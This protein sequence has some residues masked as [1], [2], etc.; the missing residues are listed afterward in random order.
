MSLINWQANGWLQPHRTSPQ[1][2]VGLLAIVERDLADSEADDLSADWRLNIAY[3]AALQSAKAAL[4]ASGYLPGKAGNAHYHTLQS[5]TLTIGL[6]SKTAGRLDAFRKR[7]NSSEY[8]TAGIT[9]D[10]EANEMRDLAR[11]ISK[12]VRE[13]LKQHH[14][15]LLKS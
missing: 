2:I 6:D 8:D 13:W 10:A 12:R 4:A 9:S 3:N 11:Q 15:Q 14:P 1:E 7:R 5:L